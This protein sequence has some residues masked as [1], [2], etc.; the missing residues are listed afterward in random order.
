MRRINLFIAFLILGLP[1]CASETHRRQRVSIGEA[2]QQA[3]VWAK[4]S[5]IHCVKPWWQSKTIWVNAL[6]A[7]LAVVTANFQLLD[8]VLPETVYKITAFSLPVINIW[9]RGSTTRGLA[10]RRKVD[11]TG[12]SQ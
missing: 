10:W 6:I 8:G 3:D 12:D 2:W 1:P 9:L 5:D 11:T 7:T 4:R